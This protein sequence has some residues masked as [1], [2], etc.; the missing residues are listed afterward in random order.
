MANLPGSYGRAMFYTG[1][2]CIQKHCLDTG[3]LSRSK[4]ISLEKSVSAY[5]SRNTIKTNRF[6]LNPS[7]KY[8]WVEIWV[9]VEGI[10]FFLSEIGIFGLKWRVN[11]L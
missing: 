10:F 5:F 8:F 4:H 11:L 1:I 9:F 3:A 2:R 6:F 7:V